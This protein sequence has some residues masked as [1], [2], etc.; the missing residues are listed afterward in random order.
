MLVRPLWG[1]GAN[2]SVAAARLS[3]KNPRKTLSDATLTNGSSSGEV[4]IDSATK[5]DALSNNIQVRMIGSVGND[6]RGIPLINNLEQ[7]GVD[8]SGVQTAYGKDT[9]L[10]IAIVDTETGENRLLI[11]PGANRHLRPEDFLTLE[12]L[13]AGY[14]PDIVITNLVIPRETT[15]QILETA[16][17]N[18]ISTLL[19][20]SPAQYLLRP[21]YRM[22]SHLIVN[23]TEAAMLTDRPVEE[24]DDAEGWASVT[25]KF[26]QMGVKNVVVTLGAK[27]AYYSNTIGHGGFV[28][29]EKGIK[30]L[31]VTG[32]G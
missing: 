26:L 16:S 5:N 14:R 24:L 12:S 1:K 28:E 27:G 9:G 30:V 17:S 20:P 6:G 7:N 31:D 25:D 2:T 15:E 32:A 4:S 29:A 13:A 21:V 18:G 3:R 11:T 8:T 19:N 22:V 23:E 10:C